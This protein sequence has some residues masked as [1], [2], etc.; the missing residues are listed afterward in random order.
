MGTGAGTE[1]GTE[2]GHGGSDSEGSHSDGNE[3]R[4]QIR[5]G[6]GWTWWRFGRLAL[7]H[8]VQSV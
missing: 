7:P 6:S 4:D 2:T 5:C 3:E 8:I 1:T